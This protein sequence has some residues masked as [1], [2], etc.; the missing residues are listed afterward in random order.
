MDATALENLKQNVREATVTSLDEGLSRLLAALPADRPKH[1]QL[2]VLR[3]RYHN[4]VGY[5]TNNTLAVDQLLV[6]EN[7]LRQDILLFTDHLSLS[8]FAAA[9]AGRPELRPGHLL[10]QI[11][12]KMKVRERYAC[13]V[14]IAHRL[15]QLLENLDPAIHHEIEAV[16]VAE[17]M[18]V[19]IIDPSAADDPA[20]DILLV[21][22]G[23]QLVDEY[24]YTEWVFYV[25]P[26]RTGAQE[27][28]LK[29][30]VLITVNEKERTKNLVFTRSI[31]VGAESASIT[32][33]RRVQTT[34]PG[35]GAGEE[36]W[37]EE[38]DYEPIP[39]IMGRVD[40]KAP[41]RVPPPRPVPAP[42]PTA[43]P[44]RRSSRPW[45][46]IAGALLFLIVATFLLLPNENWKNN[47]VTPGDVSSS[48]P[49]STRLQSTEVQTGQQ[50]QSVREDLLR[51]YRENPEQQ[52]IIYGNY[53][54][55][56]SAPAGY[57]NMGQYRAEKIKD[58]LI[59]DI[60]EDKITT[61][62]QLQRGKVPE[63]Q[64][65]L[66]AG[67][68][69]WSTRSVKPVDADPNR[70]GIRIVP[71]LEPERRVIPKDT[72]SIRRTPSRQ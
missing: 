38:G 21:S 34:P 62:A 40:T 61:S 44:P 37:E 72:L 64:E 45:L 28:I 41:G 60:P 25:R 59:K 29:V 5:K 6:L 55:T 35:A 39:P 24:S 16:P 53:F 30:S 43:T 36:I 27:L 69:R 15:S 48:Y 8:D 33:L 32:P 19:E 42:A 1:R 57:E 66:R 63:K 7:E 2:L 47:P 9:P 51:Q 70:E 54:A 11:P 23:E 18:E 68:F 31:E 4:L 17:V 50:W 49:V 52:L 20:F 26:L 3:G 46:K 56:E 10:Y 65:S 71:Q 67:S 13:R 12:D 58:L 14:R 22:D